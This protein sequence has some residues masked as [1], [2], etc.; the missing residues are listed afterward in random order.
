MIKSRRAPGPSPSLCFPFFSLFPQ[1]PGPFGVFTTPRSRGLFYP[2]LTA[3]RTAAYPEA[4]PCIGS[5]SAGRQLSGRPRFVS[6]MLCRGHECATQENRIGS[7]RGSVPLRHYSMAL[8]K[9]GSV[10]EYWR[11]FPALCVMKA[12]KRYT[13]KDLFHGRTARSFKIEVS[14]ARA[15]SAQGAY[16]VSISV[17]P[18]GRR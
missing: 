4:L 14:R 8:Q 18:A 12:L 11:L 5:S 9:L 6:L 3:C 2:G 17:R 1:N 16:Q 10:Y 7:R 15:K 13:G